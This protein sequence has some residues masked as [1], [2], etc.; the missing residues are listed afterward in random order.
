MVLEP[1]EGLDRPQL[2]LGVF[3]VAGVLLQ[4][5]DVGGV[6]GQRGQEM[7]DDDRAEADEGG[8]RRLPDDEVAAAEIADQGGHGLRVADPAQALEEGPLGVLVALPGQGVEQGDGGRLA[9]SD[10]GVHGLFL[11]LLDVVLDHLDRAARC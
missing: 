1:A 3:P 10:E 6:E 5:L 9:E 4:R 7:P 2:E 11:D 8:D